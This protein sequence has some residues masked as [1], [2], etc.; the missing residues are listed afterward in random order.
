[1][2]RSLFHVMLV[3]VNRQRG[4]AEY[5]SV[6][7]TLRIIQSTQHI[8]RFTR[9]TITRNLRKLM[10]DKITHPFGFAQGGFSQALKII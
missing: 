10:C 1:M 9:N 8:D 4:A 6:S 2:A 3:K 7:D 5:H